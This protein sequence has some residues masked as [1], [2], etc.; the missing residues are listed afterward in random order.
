M[1]WYIY[2]PDFTRIGAVEKTTSMRWTR[3]W[4][5][6]GAFELE[7]P[8][9]KTVFNVLQC[10]NLI[11]HNGEAGIIEYMHLSTGEEGETINCGGR[12]LLGYA[13]RRLVLGTASLSGPAETVMTQ[14][15][16]SNMTNGDRAFT[17]LSVAASQGRGNTV[18]YQG[19]NAN[20]LTEL[21]GLSA[22]SGL[23]MTIAVTDAG[24]SFNVLAGLD[25]SANQSANPRAIFSPEFENV[26]SQDYEI[27]TGNSSTVAVVGYEKDGITETVGTKK[28]RERREIFIS[29]SN[30]DKN[31]SG[32]TLTEA[33]KRAIMRE[34]GE[35]AL[36]EALVS[37][38]FEAEVNP[39][40]NLKYKTHYDLGDIITVASKRWGL[41]IDARITEITEVYDASGMRLELTL[42]YRENIK[43]M[44][45]RLI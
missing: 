20:L 22:L 44:L 43:K 6:A 4:H 28:G 36:A 8:F 24:M 2:T 12:F 35:T 18:E 26:Q 37:E 23:G 29:A 45:G 14:L 27:D 30:L 33:Q 13:A 5:T 3:R 7:M 40:G 15:V 34:Q 16:S 21:E 32:G 9:D 39:Y 38:S 1:L 11:I 41:Q 10:E 19:T 17:G 31:E 42:G 25:R